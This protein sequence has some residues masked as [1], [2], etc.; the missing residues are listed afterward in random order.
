[1][2]ARQ[3]WFVRR[4]EWLTRLPYWLCLP[5]SSHIVAISYLLLQVYILLFFWAG[6]NTLKG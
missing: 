3:T 5:V 4:F 1:M 6:V 2:F